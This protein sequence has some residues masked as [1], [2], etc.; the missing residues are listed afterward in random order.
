MEICKMCKTLGQFFELLYKKTA[1]LV[2]DTLT[3]ISC[4]L[5]AAVRP[6]YPAMALW[7]HAGLAG[8]TI[9]RKCEQLMSSSGQTVL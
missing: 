8:L 6:E 2:F 1:A 5:W 3:R 7:A 9:C 4:R